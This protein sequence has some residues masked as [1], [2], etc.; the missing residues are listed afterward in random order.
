MSSDRSRIAEV[1]WTMHTLNRPPEEVVAALLPVI[2][3]AR[4]ESYAAGVHAGRDEVLTALETIQANG[5][6]EGV[7]AALPRSEGS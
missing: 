1:V 3:K 7:V 2:E 5:D 6:V 4:E